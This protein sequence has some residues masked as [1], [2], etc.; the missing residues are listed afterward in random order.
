MEKGYINILSAKHGK[1]RIIKVKPSTLAM[2][3]DYTRRHNF[4]I[5]AKLFPS[6]SVISNTF[7]RLRTSIARKLQNPRIRKVRL[8]DFRHYFAT[9]LYCERKDLL[10]TKEMLGHRNINNTMVY[11]H[12]IRLDTDDKH[13]VATAKT[14]EEASK[15]LSIGYEFVHEYNGIMIYRKRK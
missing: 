9:T 2:M 12:L 7:A 15:L 6:S 1:P 14:I 8:Y 3:K 11:T 5:E 10:L 4:D 13:N